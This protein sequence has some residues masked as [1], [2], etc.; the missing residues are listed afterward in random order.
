M[1]NEFYRRLQGPG[2]AGAAK[3]A[4]LKEHPPVPE[5]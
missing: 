4:R 3:T 2:D 1:E 5:G